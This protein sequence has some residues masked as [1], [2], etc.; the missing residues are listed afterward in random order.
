MRRSLQRDQTITATHDNAAAWAGIGAAAFT[1]WCQKAVPASILGVLS[2]FLYLS[3]VLVLHITTPALF[4]LET[5][6]ASRP[7]VV[8]T[9]GLPSYNWSK[10]ENGLLG[11]L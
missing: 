2:T 6:N 7:F 4:S 9:Q 10:I 1:V 8:P 3:G 11:D 5:V